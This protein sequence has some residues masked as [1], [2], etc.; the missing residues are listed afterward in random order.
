VRSEGILQEVEF[1]LDFK[2]TLGGILDSTDAEEIVL[3]FSGKAPEIELIPESSLWD[4]VT[5]GPCFLCREARID[6]TSLLET[7]H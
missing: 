1:S 7:R 3:L 6:W 5:L 4:R 2:S